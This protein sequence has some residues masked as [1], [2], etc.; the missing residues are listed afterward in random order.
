M[1]KEYIK[2]KSKEEEII[3]ILEKREDLEA[4]KNAS[5]S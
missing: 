4:K 3:K 1:N 5:F 2:I